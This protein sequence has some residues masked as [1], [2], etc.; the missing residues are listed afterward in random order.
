MNIQY[1][2]KGYINKNAELKPRTY[3]ALI[4]T[5]LGGIPS[6]IYG[7]TT[8]EPLINALK[9]G[10]AGT[11][12]GGGLGYLAPLSAE[13]ALKQLSPADI[14]K[15]LQSEKVR[16]WL[17]SVQGLTWQDIF[18]SPKEKFFKTPGRLIE[19]LKML[20]R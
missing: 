18:I 5:A 12:A 13:S 7:A 16:D 8:D 6:A 15:Q 2:C 17:K 10:T 3:N 11:L 1:F 9:Y 20:K 14:T 19:V 4:G